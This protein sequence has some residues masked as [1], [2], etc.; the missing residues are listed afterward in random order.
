MST[1]GPAGPAATDEPERRATP[2]SS[3]AASP[4]HGP[5]PGGRGGHAQAVLGAVC[6]TCGL[7]KAKACFSKTQWC[8]PLEKRKCRECAEQERDSRGRRPGVDL[9][10]RDS[11]GAPPPTGA[12]DSPQRSSPPARERWPS[13]TAHQQP[14]DRAS[15]RADRAGAGAAAGAGWS[16]CPDWRNEGDGAAADR[17]GLFVP[18]WRKREER[19][20]PHGGRGAAAAD[21]RQSAEPLPAPSGGAGAPNWRQGGPGP[22]PGGRGEGVAPGAGGG[23]GQPRAAEGGP[24]LPRPAEEAECE[25][26]A[27][28]RAEGIDCPGLAKSLVFHGIDS[29][30]F[31]R[32]LLQDG[33]DEDL[34]AVFADASVRRAVAARLLA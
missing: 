11:E 17:G 16:D 31:L 34:G 33:D 13:G 1:P 9:I 5:Q 7:R 25:A 10:P 15:W 14:P 3:G 24:S 21:W 26:V 8:F 30:E 22:S 28:L 6:C 2:P 29:V 32:E 20:Q 27:W 12:A 19:P 4:R 18:A 23:R